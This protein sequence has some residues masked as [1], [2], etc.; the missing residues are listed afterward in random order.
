MALSKFLKVLRHVSRNIFLF[1]SKEPPNLLAE[2]RREM[3]FGLSLH[4]DLEYSRSIL[5]EK[6]IH[7]L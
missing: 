3:Y 2:H 1:H 4:F 6:I 7:L 5:Q